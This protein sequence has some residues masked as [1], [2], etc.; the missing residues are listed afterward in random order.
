MSTPAWAVYRLWRHKQGDHSRSTTIAMVIR[1]IISGGFAAQILALY[2]HNQD[3][4]RRLLANLSTYQP[5]ILFRMRRTVIFSA[6]A[7]VLSTRLWKWKRVV[8]IEER[9]GIYRIGDRAWELENGDIG[10]EAA[11][12]RV[13]V[14]GLFGTKVFETEK[15]VP[16]QASV[17]PTARRTMLVARQRNARLQEPR[18][19]RS[20]YWRI[21]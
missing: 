17:L 8:G 7:N 21:C 6:V 5:G 19:G 15:N 20:G 11:G 14:T 13:F 9:G 10:L 4:L 1:C 3:S 18:I 2:S 16:S 12:G